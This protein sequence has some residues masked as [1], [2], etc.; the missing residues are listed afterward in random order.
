MAVAPPA[1]PGVPSALFTRIF[2]LV[3]AT[4]AVVQLIGV[5]LLAT[6]PPEPPAA[7]SLSQLARAVAGRDETL[8]L[9]TPVPQPP[10]PDPDEA[11]AA[12]L[13]AGDLARTLGLPADAVRLDLAAIQNGKLVQTVQPGRAG[14][15]PSVELALTGHFR[16]AI[17]DGDDGWLLMEP[18]DRTL[19][20]SRDR[21]YLLLF[22]ASA[23]AMLPLVWL[24]SR[25]LA[26]P[27]A[28]F[29]DA[30]ERLGRDPAAPLPDIDGPAEVRRAAGAFALMQQRL[31]AYV[32]DRTEMMA[33]I[34]HDLR[35]PLTRLAFRIEALEPARR[36]PMAAD[37]AEM[38]AMLDATLDFART[39]GAP[40][41]RRRLDLGALLE[42]VADGLAEIGR[43]VS[44]QAP[45]GLVVEADPLALRRLFANLFDN[46]V[47]YGGRV[48]AHAQPR[49]GM[50]VIAFDDEGPGVPEAD[51]A[52]LFDPFQRLE[53][54]RSRATGGTGLG[55]SVVRSIARGHGGDAMLENRAGGGLRAVVQ[56]PLAD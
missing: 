17:R 16:L 18:R 27:F 49:D 13:L 54:S 5:S 47:K 37:I 45:A 33:A 4:V 12:H 41:E 7:L 50:A 28:Q 34:A 2:A 21:R 29:A 9:I 26:A 43:P 31:Q 55:L 42:Q 14:R 44:A 15:R 8:L 11:R 40:A 36:D 35:T 52:R 38:A 24:V 6:L 48:H 56:L 25:R 22:L 53:T 20:A 10:A 23:L 39:A 1:R 30:A 32:T 46:G 3:L 51:L 19:L